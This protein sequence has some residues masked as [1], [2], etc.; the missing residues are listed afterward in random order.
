M[1]D[2]NQDQRS[3][4]LLAAIETVQTPLVAIARLQLADEF[5]TRE[6][7]VKLYAAYRKLLGADAEAFNKLSET[8]PGD[9][10][11]W[12]GRVEKYGEAAAK[13]Q[14]APNMAALEARNVTSQCVTEFRKEHRLLMH[15]LESKALLEK[16][17]YE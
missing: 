15:L 13:E 16:G 2:N 14:L 5:Y 17:K 7:R 6:E 9:D 12:D 10:L 8:T 4:A 11:S 3:T 1:T